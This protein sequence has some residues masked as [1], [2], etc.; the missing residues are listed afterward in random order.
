MRTLVHR[1]VQHITS[2]T[3][4]ADYSPRL[5]D[6]PK[7]EEAH[8]H[9]AL[10]DGRSSGRDHRAR[11]SC[12]TQQHTACAAWPRSCGSS[13]AIEPRKRYCSRSQWQAG[14]AAAVAVVRAARACANGPVGLVRGSR[15]RSGGLWVVLLIVEE[16]LLHV[17]GIIGY[18]SCE[19]WMRVLRPDQSRLFS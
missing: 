11:R 1:K 9:S 12:C 14:V 8:V 7:E 3:S 2:S 10:V 5:P 17:W 16:F 4:D 19:S 18:A 13:S 15:A 6:R